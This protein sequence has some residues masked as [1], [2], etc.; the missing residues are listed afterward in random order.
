M[1]RAAG[2]ACA[3]LV[4]AA[5]W[6][7]P[8]DAVAQ[9][10]VEAAVLECPSVL[11]M[12]RL[13]GREFCDVMTGNDPAQGILVTLPPRQGDITLS[14]DLHN[15]HTYSEDLIRAGR[16]SRRYT[17]TI[18]VLTMNNDLLTRAIVQSEFRTAADLEDRIDGGAGPGGVKAVAPTGTERIV[19]T[20]P[21]NA[22]QVSILGE[23]LEV[24]RLDSPVPDNFIGLGRPIALIS[25]VVVE[26]RPR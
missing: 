10:R 6:G 1:S 25:N 16:G 8:A 19:L 20:I 22:S 23:K 21:G 2:F 14:F 4:A 24:V 5:V 17:A 9:A 26:Y 11:G 13:T 7:V 3:A 18:G 15:R 12:G